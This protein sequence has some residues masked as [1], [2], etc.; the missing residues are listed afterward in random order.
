MRGQHLESFNTI[1]QSFAGYDTKPDLSVAGKIA[2]LEG[3][4]ENWEKR[5]KKNPYFRYYMAKLFKNDEPLPGGRVSKLRHLDDAPVDGV[6]EGAEGLHP[7]LEGLAS[8]ALER[9]AVGAERAPGEPLPHVLHEDL[10][11]PDGRRPADHVPG[12][13]AALVVHRP[14]AAGVGVVGAFGGGQEYVQ[15]AAGD[16]D[17]GIHAV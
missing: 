12:A 16:D 13:G 6:V 5:V 11:D 1:E 2:R 9:P 15:V 10:V 14:P 3:Y 4:D 7:G 17:L 8:A